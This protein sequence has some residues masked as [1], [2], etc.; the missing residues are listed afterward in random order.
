MRTPVLR[1]RNL[2]D[3]APRAAFDRLVRRAV[4]G[5]GASPFNDQA[6]ID[7]GDGSRSLVFAV[8]P[9]ESPS[10]AELLVGAVL[11]GQ[12]E[13]ELVVDPEW[14]GTGV[15]TAMLTGILLD[16]PG[17]L[18]A[19]AHGDHPASRALATRFGFERV[20]TLL[21]LRMPLEPGDDIPPLPDGITTFRP[22]IDDAE[23]VELNARVFA[24]HPEQGRITVD[25]VRARRA[26]PWFD[27]GDFLLARDDAGRMIGYNWLKIDGESGEIYVIGVGEPGRGLG[28]QL[29]VAG[30]DRLRE[31]GVTTASLYVEGD[32]E[33]AVALYRSLGFTDHTVDIQ[34]RRGAT[35]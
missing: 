18:L 33:R 34:Y 9:P 13:L 3:A 1:S 28:R 19:W 12:G 17:D 15:G 24:D 5:D 11:I 25:D 8:A 16:A 14:R 20:R 7:A 2:A 31:R 22:D 27:A 26:E 35:A 4:A 10:A 23:W 32:N 29:M 30:L 6:L 21:Q